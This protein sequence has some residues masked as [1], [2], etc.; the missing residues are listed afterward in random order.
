[1]FRLSIQ[2]ERKGTDDEPLTTHQA[3]ELHR[4]RVTLRRRIKHLR[5]MQ[6]AYMPG[7][8]MKCRGAQVSASSVG[9]VEDEVLWLPSDFAEAERPR[10]C[11][12]RLPDIEVEHHIS[13]MRDALESIRSSQ[14]VIH[15][16]HVYRKKNV[17][18]QHA[19]TRAATFVDHQTALCNHAR[20][21]YT[22]CWAALARL[23]GNDLS[24]ESEHRELLPSHC[25]ALQGA[26]FDTDTL[27]P[28]G[29]GTYVI[30]WIWTVTGAFD[31]ASPELLQSVKREWLKS[32]ARVMRWS[33]KLRLT[34]E[35][36]RRA[37]VS[38]RFMELWWEQRRTRRLVGDA[39]LMKGSAAY[40]AHQAAVQKDLRMSFTTLW[41][42]TDE[43]G[44]YQDIP[45]LDGKMMGLGPTGVDGDEED[46]EDEITGP[47]I[48]A[49]DI[50]L[51]QNP[52]SSMIS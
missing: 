14:I 15:A 28:L 41:D 42:L 5:G 6:M 30:S 9:D 18:G 45:W 34:E 31:G 13:Q 50:S 12:I 49:P 48:P 36:M 33:E 51:K 40:A 44:D 7:A 4:R 35:E 19:L 21:R 27:L 37:R 22:F 43:P 2:R 46:E 38:L 8:A 52:P 16:Y 25:V 29:Q 10:A 20:I 24:W 3:S 32:R 26:E 39:A 23:K 17:R 11:S 1:M 47:G